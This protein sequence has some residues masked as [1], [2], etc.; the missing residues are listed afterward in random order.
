MGQDTEI[1]K[2]LEFLL[3]KDSRIKKIIVDIIRDDFKRFKEK[4][5]E[6]EETETSNIL[7]E[8]IFYPP[9]TGYTSGISF[10]NK[11][12]HKIIGSPFSNMI[13]ETVFLTFKTKTVFV[14]DIFPVLSNL[15]ENSYDVR[16]QDLVKGAEGWNK[17]SD[18]QE[19][20]YNIAVYKKEDD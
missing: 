14:E 7:S 1:R 5:K 19:T 15:Q 9:Q 11:F 16:L 20:Y 2:T 3:E 8:V 6:E 17:T 4:E 12:G 13:K 18:G 10:K